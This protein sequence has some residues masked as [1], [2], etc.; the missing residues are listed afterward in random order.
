MR[1][2]PASPKFGGGKTIY[3]QGF[4][5]NIGVKKFKIVGSTEFL[6]QIQLPIVSGGKNFTDKVNIQG[7]GYWGLQ[8]HT[9][10]PVGTKILENGSYMMF[11]NY[12]FLEGQALMVRPNMPESCTV[13]YCFDHTREGYKIICS[14]IHQTHRLPILNTN[15]NFPLKHILFA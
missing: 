12:H 14:K 13:L 4:R 3:F 10:C 9:F 6:D 5:S 1:I 8:H 2:D 7:E 15:Y 11:R